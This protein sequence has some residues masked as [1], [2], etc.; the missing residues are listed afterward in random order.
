MHA[1][2]VEAMLD[3]LGLRECADTIVG[4]ELLRGISGGQKKRLTLGEMIIGN[5]RLLLLDEIS[6]GLDAA[7]T[8]D[9]TAALKR[10]TRLLEGSVVASLLQ[11]TPETYALFD[12][13][14]LLREGSIVYSGPRDKIKDYFASIGVP[15]RFDQ[16]E[17]DFLVDFLT[18]PKLTYEKSMAKMRQAA[19]LAKTQTV[20]FRSLFNFFMFLFS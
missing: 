6:T 2:R 9:I 18:D 16:D 12:N 15:M 7:T 11:P 1:E 10:W 17:A 4:D 19:A 5:A 3:L 14:I 8:I 20:R 13:V